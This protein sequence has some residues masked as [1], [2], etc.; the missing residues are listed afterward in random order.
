MPE[1]VYRLSIA[2]ALEAFRPEIEHVCTFLED[3]YLIR[4][5][6]DAARVLHYGPGAPAGAV[7]IPAVLFQQHNSRQTATRQIGTGRIKR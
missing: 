2:P 3:C 4:R 6:P 5:T 1:L 7:A